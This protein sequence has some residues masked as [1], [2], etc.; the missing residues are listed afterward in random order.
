M[1]RFPY[2]EF[3]KDL[4]KELLQSQGIVESSR[5]VKSEIREIDVYFAPSNEATVDTSELGLLKRF[6]ETS[7][8]LEPFRNAVEP[9]EVRDCISKLFDVF[10]EL[11][12]Q[13]KSKKNK[14]LE[15]DLPRLWILTPTASQSILEGFKCS[16][17]EKNWGKGIYF[18]GEYMRAA[19]VVIHQLPKTPETIWLRLLGKG[20]V[21]EQAVTELLALSED[22]P[23][24]SKAIDLL[25]NLKAN[26]E[27]KKKRG[28]EDNILIM[29]LLPIYQSQLAEAKA[30]AKQEG[31]QQ[32]IQQGVQEA[33][34]LY[35]QRLAEAERNAQL[36]ERNAQ[37]AERNAQRVIVEN[38]LRNRFGPLDEELTAIVEPLLNMSPDEFTPLLL[39]LSKEELLA[40]FG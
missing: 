28:Q 39:Q 21:Q 9:S 31:I 35:E 6:T 18:F 37:L 15:K 32:G 10:N 5:K 1:T 8:L 19:I 24:R 13:S 20:K 12:R 30:E 2:D 36:A 34:Q 3:A 22:N 14:L 4:L 11:E 27:L 33:T 38:F 29:A 23:L 7:A 40:R 17:D 25:M 16:P 26:V